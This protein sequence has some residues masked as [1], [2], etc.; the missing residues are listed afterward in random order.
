MDIMNQMAGQVS[1]TTLESALSSQY[2]SIQRLAGGIPAPIMTG[3]PRVI[4]TA[5]SATIA[6][7]TNKLSNS[8]VAIASASEFNQSADNPYLQVVG[9]PS[10]QTTEHIVTIYDLKPDTTYHYQ[11]RSQAALGP[12]AESADFVFQTKQETLEITNH[13]VQ[14]VST[15]EAIFKWVTNVE[16]DSL[17]RYIPYRNNVLSVDEAQTEYNKAATTIHEVAID[18]F[19]SG[20]IYEVELISKDINDNAA[21]QKISAF[22]TADDDLPP[23]IY[24]VQTASAL[25]QGKK[26]QVQTIISWKTNE[27]STTRV[28]Y[29]K[30]VVGPEQELSEETRLDENYTKK[31]VAVITKFN[32]GV[33]YSFR[34]ESVDS[35]GNVSLSKIYVILTPRQQES[36]F[37]IIMKNMED[38]FGWVG[39]MRN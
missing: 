14:I 18:N 30:G 36:V 6:W 39:K 8:L 29:Q 28:Y 11:L 10:E 33:A 24:Q 32:P 15:E 34:A 31:H 12:T 3:E 25:A 19:E 1:L 27:P 35:G 2:S 20:V 17:V 4:T 9:N 22:S 5:H 37:Q 23:V 13:T 38:I 21:A 26:T 7:Q 16:T